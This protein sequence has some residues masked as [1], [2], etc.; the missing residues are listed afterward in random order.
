MVGS[1]V[2]DVRPTRMNFRCH[3]VAFLC[4]TLPLTIQHSS[5]PLSFIALSTT[6]I[7]PK[8][9]VQF[10]SKSRINQLINY[11]M[12]ALF[13]CLFKKLTQCPPP[14]VPVICIEFVFF[15]PINSL[16]ILFSPIKLFTS[17]KNPCSKS[18]IVSFVPLA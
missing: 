10:L 5:P 6:S 17:S 1:L 16:C 7:H 14:K 3:M 2:S 12:I 18:S 8:W 15:Y 13:L 11:V 4:S 9:M